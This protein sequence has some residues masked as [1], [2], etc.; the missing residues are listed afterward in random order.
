MSITPEVRDELQQRL[1]DAIARSFTPCPL[2]GPKWFRYVG[3]KNPSYQFI[4]TAKLAKAT[5]G[6]P[7][8]VAKVLL[9]RLNLAGLPVSMAAQISADSNIFITTKAP[10]APPQVAQKPPPKAPKK[11]PQALLA[12][13]TKAMNSQ[14]KAAVPPAPTPDAPA[15]KPRKSLKFWQ[16]KPK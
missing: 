5:C 15:P 14:K 7:K 9:G 8:R 12:A 2:I 6:E 4:G 10:K 11:S 3:G 1:V 13:A 16:K